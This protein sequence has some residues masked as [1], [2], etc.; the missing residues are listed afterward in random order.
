ML[1]LGAL[2]ESLV[3]PQDLYLC[4]RPDPEAT[5]EPRLYAVW[6]GDPP[7]NPPT[8]STT[9]NDPPTSSIV[10]RQLD[11][12][13]D[14][15]TPLAVEMLAEDLPALLQNLLVGIERAICRVPLEE[16][17]FPPA[18]AECDADTPDEIDDRHNNNTDRQ[19]DNGKYILTTPGTP[20]IGLKRRELI[21]KN[22]LVNN[23]YAALKRITPSTTANGGAPTTH[24]N[25]NGNSFINRSN[26][27][28]SENTQQVNGNQCNDGGLAAGTTGGQN[29][30]A[31]KDSGIRL[32]DTGGTTTSTTSAAGV[33]GTGGNGGSSDNHQSADAAAADINSMP[34]FCL[35][36]SF[37]HIDSDEES[38]DDMKKC[39]TGECQQ[40]GI[41]ACR[42]RSASWTHMTLFDA[43]LLIWI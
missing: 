16:L 15:I 21:T 26:G 10:Y 12:A 18:A 32:H 6:R 7:S 36:G 30:N 23:K 20:K 27:E 41:N 8:T 5:S 42:W 13:K 34:L 9:V 40:P 28:K 38:G 22:K 43:F 14:P 35:G 31:A 17:S 39:E 2:D 25:T 19:Q 24:N 11:P 1:H 3:R 4:I 33:G 37:P 29:D